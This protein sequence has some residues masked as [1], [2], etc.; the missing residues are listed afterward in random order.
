[1]MFYQ[2]VICGLFMSESPVILGKTQVTRPQPDI[3]NEDF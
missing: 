1:M 2:N 3:P